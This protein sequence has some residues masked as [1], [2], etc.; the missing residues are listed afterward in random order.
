MVRFSQSVVLPP[1]RVGGELE[2]QAS[3]YSVVCNGAADACSGPHIENCG[4]REI[5]VALRHVG[6]FRDHGPDAMPL[7]LWSNW[8]PMI[9][10]PSFCHLPPPW[11]ETL[12]TAVV[13]D[14]RVEGF[15][16]T[17][18][19]LA[20]SWGQNHGRAGSVIELPQKPRRAMI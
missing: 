12:D 16:F 2:G 9:L 7:R 15:V 14:S 11:P 17:L 6:C 1:T 19:D 10:P 13:L 4:G 8:F 3:L 20:E 18:R 5:G